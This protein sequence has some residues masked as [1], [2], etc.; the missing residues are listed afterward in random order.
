M[1][2]GHPPLPGEVGGLGAGVTGC[3]WDLCSL[4]GCAQVTRMDPSGGPATSV[5]THQG[6]SQ[7]QD[8][9]ELLC[10]CLAAVVTMLQGT[11]SG[12]SHAS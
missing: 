5:I 4:V 8:G 1:P 6:C 11:A 7:T 9:A 12:L 10:L 2:G 3:A